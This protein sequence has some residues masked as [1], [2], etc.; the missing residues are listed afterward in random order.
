MFPVLMRR[1]VSSSESIP[2]VS[3]L[4]AASAVLMNNKKL[5]SRTQPRRET[6][7]YSSDDK[8]PK[9]HNIT[10]KM[11]PYEVLGVSQRDFDE[12]LVKKQYY[13]LCKE[14]HP[15]LKQEDDKEESNSSKKFHMIKDAYFL[16]KDPLLKKQYDS[17]GL[18]WN[19]GSTAGT[20]TNNSE[21]I[22][23]ESAFRDYM[24]ASSF[25]ERA[26]YHH[27]S[28]NKTNFSS[29]NI[30][31][32]KNGSLL[33]GRTFSKWELFGWAILIAYFV[34]LFFFIGAIDYAASTDE[35]IN[36]KDADWQFLMRLDLLNAYTN[37]GLSMQD[38]WNRIRRFLFFRSFENLHQTK[39]DDFDEDQTTGQ[40]SYSIG[41]AEKQDTDASMNV[42][43]RKNEARVANLKVKMRQKEEGVKI[44]EGSHHEE[45][46][47]L[48][49]GEVKLEEGEVKLKETEV[50]PKEGELKPKEEEVKLSDKK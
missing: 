26:T 44:K 2:S 6:N 49:E 1:S 46:V 36:V 8:A 20:N 7:R 13:K 38:P 50:K 10:L 45:E 39:R 31:H 11:T 14:Y 29:H 30:H 16:L 3:V 17:F 9:Q 34:R 41:P 48:K 33:S 32:F 37:H 43:V 19:H 12:K 15:D 40:L 28:R 18:G 27:S 25:Y 35:T 21:D 4:S 23:S 42:L 47:E 22:M 24:N 5:F